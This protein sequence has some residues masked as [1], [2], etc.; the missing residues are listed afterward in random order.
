MVKAV[1]GQMSGCLR[2]MS[3]R[4]SRGLTKM[5]GRKRCSGEA[6]SDSSSSTKKAKRDKL[7]KQRLRN[8]RESTIANTRHFPGFAARWSVIRYTSRPYTVR[9]VRSTKDIC[10]LSRILTL[11]GS[12]GPLTRKSAIFWIMLGA[13]C[14]R[15][16]WRER[17]QRPL[18]HMAS[19]LCNLRQSDALCR[20][21][22]FAREQ[23]W[24]GYSTCAL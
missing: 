22:I 5:T 1:I 2:E 15:P 12:P 18:E 23:G 13:G 19:R 7:R 14:T 8:G 3:V 9:F 10:S 20:R 11:P 21:L 17:G 16:R 6:A 4:A 24:D